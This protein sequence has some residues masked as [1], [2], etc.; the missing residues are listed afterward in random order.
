MDR[1]S[2]SSQRVAARV[3]AAIEESEHSE[4]GVADITGIARE[5]LRR[6]LAGQTAF[7]I[8]E[9]E[10]VADALNLGDYTAFVDA[11][12]SRAS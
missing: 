1:L 3:R 2:G 12:E 8:D 11:P 10:A 9:L 7:T 5:T 6:R 4:R